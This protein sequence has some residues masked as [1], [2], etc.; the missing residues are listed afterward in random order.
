M[1]WWFPSWKLRTALITSSSQI[2]QMLHSN[3]TI[4]QS[5]LIVFICTRIDNCKPFRRHPSAPM[6]TLGLHQ[7][8]PSLLRGWQML[9]SRMARLPTTIYCLAG[10]RKCPTEFNSQPST[11]RLYWESLAVAQKQTWTSF[12][13]FLPLLSQVTRQWITDP[14]FDWQAL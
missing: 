1:P 14:S 13:A 7:R 10:W 2:K 9:W 3:H 12:L 4:C 11:G 8:Q 5:Y 6:S